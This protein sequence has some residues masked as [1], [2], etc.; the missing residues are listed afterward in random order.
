MEKLREYG[1]QEIKEFLIFAINDILVLSK[2]ME[3]SLTGL[4]DSKGPLSIKI[5]VNQ[6]PFIFCELSNYFKEQD[7]INVPVNYLNALYR[8]VLELKVIGKKIESFS[9]Q[10]KISILDFVNKL[11]L[12][13][14]KQERGGYSFDQR[15]IDIIFMELG[16]D[17]VDKIGDARNET[18]ALLEILMMKK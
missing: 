16:L 14:E 5:S 3:R 18:L 6:K 9:E 11:L 13:R 17:V 4:E 8:L 15:Y 2:E 1:E 10:E 12:F 7:F